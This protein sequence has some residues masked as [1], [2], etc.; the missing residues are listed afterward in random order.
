MRR[1]KQRIDALVE[2]FGFNGKYYGKSAEEKSAGSFHA[3]T[4]RGST[5][6]LFNQLFNYANG[7]YD[8][9]SSLGVTDKT[10]RVTVGPIDTDIDTIGS[11]TGFW[12]DACFNQSELLQGYQRLAQG[13]VDFAEKNPLTPER[14]SQIVDIIPALYLPALES[15]KA[16][17]IANV[18]HPCMATI[19]NVYSTLNFVSSE[20]G[21]SPGLRDDYLLLREKSVYN[22]SLPVYEW[23]TMPNCSGDQC[24]P[25][26]KILNG[27]EVII[28]AKDKFYNYVTGGLDLPLPLGMNVV[29]ESHIKVLQEKLKRAEQAYSAFTGEALIEFQ[30]A[31]QEAKAAAQRQLQKGSAISLP[32]PL[33]DITPQRVVARIISALLGV[34][35]AIALAMFVYG[36]LRWMTARGNPED[37]KKARG[38]IVWAALGLL[39]IFGAYAVVNFLLS[40]FG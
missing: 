38:T 8:F 30:K 4:F 11:L 14:I 36:G 20:P 16:P 23:Y 9:I 2:Y 25:S 28:Y 13:Y 5:L 22:G 21:I 7:L 33:S 31:E 12:R 6:Y 15:I 19:A 3:F 10:V 1:D 37:V 18:P 17:T 32:L 39:M 26:V 24:K 40:S 34:V 29:L 35:G 27:D